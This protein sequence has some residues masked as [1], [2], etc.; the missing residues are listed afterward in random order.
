MVTGFRE[1]TQI[2]YDGSYSDRSSRARRL[3][4]E[5]YSQPGAEYAPYALYQQLGTE[6]T[7]LR[8]DGCYHCDLYGQDRYTDTKPDA[9]ARAQLLWYK[10][11][12]QPVRRRYQHAYRRRY[13]HQFNRFS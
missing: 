3:A 4:H 1:D 12:Q 9:G 10:E 5:R 13:Q 11:R 2:L 6:D 7:R 8:N